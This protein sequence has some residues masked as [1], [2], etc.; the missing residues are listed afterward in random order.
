MAFLLFHALPA[1]AVT[2]NEFWTYSGYPE[3]ITSGPDGNLWFTEGRSNKIGRITPAGVITEFTVPT[4]DSYPVGIV[5]GPDGNLWFTENSGNKIGMITTAG[6]FAEYAIPT[7]DSGPWGIASG[8]DGNLWFTEF[9]GNKIGNITTDGTT[10][11]EYDVPTASSGPTEIT[12]G[13]DGNLWFTEY[14][15]N[16]I[17]NVTTDGTT[18]N[19]YTVPTGA[20]NPW[21]ITTGPD[22]NI[23]FAEYA[24]SNIGQLIV[25]TDPIV[26]NEYPLYPD[27]QGEPTGITVG[28]DGNIWFSD[29]FF[30]NIGQVTGI[31]ATVTINEYPVPTSFSWPVGLVTGPDHN[32][33]FA[34][35]N[36]GKIGQLLVVTSGPSHTVTPSA[37]S[38]GSISPNTPQTVNYGDSTSFTVSPDAGY[39]ISSVTGCGGLLSNGTYTT[40]AITA[41][42]TVSALFAINTYT[43]TPFAGANGSISPNTYQTVDY[44]QTIQFTVTPDSGYYAIMGGTCGGSLA[45]SIYTTDPVT[46]SCSVIADFSVIPPSAGFSGT[47]TSGAAPLSVGFTDSSSNNPTS[48][49]WIFGDG[50]TSALQNPTHVYQDAGTYNVSLTVANAGGNSTLTQNGY[51]SVSCPVLPARITGTP[52]V[53]YSSLQNAFNASVNGNVI[54]VQAVTLTEAADLN[55][56]AA[57]TFK[58]GYDGCYTTNSGTYSTISGSLTISSGSATVENIIVQ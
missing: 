13:P 26:I 57:V 27:K 34:E 39:H 7:A 2:I 38:N 14:S 43:V 46:A 40:G 28:F 55:S 18:F 35:L 10:L 58:G 42:C 56:G 29:S 1:G 53:Y 54:Q 44:N 6:V 4:A 15:G 31:G 12:T 21:G 24:G 30:G 49:S 23:W 3:Y 48:W 32:L 20:S 19:E 47:P 9:A 8:P 33:W 52:P 41:D 50:G 17:G 45:G 5:T 25:G 22:N 51:I 36:A 11:N 37:G 16:K